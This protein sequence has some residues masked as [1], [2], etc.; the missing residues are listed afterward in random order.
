[1]KESDFQTKFSQWLKYNF[2]F[3]F[4]YE[5]KITHGKSIAF[6]QFKKQQIPSLISVSTGNIGL[7]HKISDASYESKPFDGFKLF[8]ERSL[9]ILFYVRPNQRE[10][11]VIDIID[12]E[13]EIKECSRKS[14]TEA[15][16]KEIGQVYELGKIY[17]E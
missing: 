10:F 7:H 9:V 3:T 14:I 4:A 13:K 5:I 17:S 1:M 6:D 12:L 11:I 15:R 2:H 16:A 8:K